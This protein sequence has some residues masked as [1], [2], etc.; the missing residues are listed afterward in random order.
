M[1]DASY[2][3]IG[4]FVLTAM[5]LILGGVL[6][7]GASELLGSQNYLETF[8][9][10]SVEGL[11]SGSTV[12]YRGVEI[13]TVT[14]IELVRNAYGE[15]KPPY[16][17]VVFRVAL[18]LGDDRGIDEVLSR[19]EGEGLRIKLKSSFVSGTSVLEADYESLEVETFTPTWP[20]E[21][22]YVES[23]PS[24]TVQIEKTLRD[25]GQRLL[26]QLDELNV[27]EVVG[28]VTTALDA[29]TETLNALH[30]R[31]ASK[32]IDGLLAELTGAAAAARQLLE[33][34]RDS[35]PAVMTDVDGLVSRATKV[36]DNVDR[37]MVDG[38]LASGIRAVSDGGE[39]VGK[40]ADD[41]SDLVAQVRGLVLSADRTLLDQRRSLTDLIESLGAVA[42][43]LEGVMADVDRYPSRVFFGDPPPP[44]RIREK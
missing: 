27:K 31:T 16:I 40:I 37:A 23:V 38:D 4:V 43:H 17:R 7:L 24:R 42:R 9:D 15:D 33:E 10:E 35:V 39:K 28:G 34:T 36:V 6:L 32:E 30:E 14:R 26:A 29:M 18:P 41:F 21:F 22:R 8:F 12:L 25:A 3:K 11:S 13:G 20:T 19:A 44:T 5:G 2:F 1:T